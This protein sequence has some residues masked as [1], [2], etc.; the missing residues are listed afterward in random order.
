MGVARSWYGQHDARLLPDGHILMFDNF[1][2][3]ETTGH[4]RSRALEIDPVTQRVVWSWSGDRAHP[5]DSEIRGAVER[6]PDGDTLITDSDGGHIVEVTPQGEVAW[7]YY[8]PVRVDG[9]GNRPF[10]ADSISKTRDPVH[11]NHPR[12]YI[13]VVGYAQRIG[14]G[15]LDPDF[16]AQLKQ[17][18]LAQNP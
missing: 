16:R 10:A 5:L 11:A 7:E 1:G 9:P 2:N 8:N 14:S 15:T 3:F 12:Q 13:P 6:E 17:R 4:G 18:L